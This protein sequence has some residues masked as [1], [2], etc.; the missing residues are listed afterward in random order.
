MEKKLGIF[1]GTIPLGYVAQTHLV[2]VLEV[3]G[4][5]GVCIVYGALGVSR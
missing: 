5:G 2:E 4:G 3:G 1:L